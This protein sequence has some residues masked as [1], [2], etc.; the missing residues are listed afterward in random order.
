MIRFVFIFIGLFLST[1]SFAQQDLRFV[2]LQVFPD[3]KTRNIQ[4][5]ANQTWSVN[6]GDSVL[7][8]L[9][10]PQ[11]SIDE[12][13]VNKKSAH[14]ERLTD[15]ISI[16]IPQASST[17]KLS[18]TYHG[19]P[20]EAI[21][22]PWDG[23]FIWT[24]SQNEKDWL[25]VACQEQGSQLWFPSP[26]RYDD[27]PDSAQISCTY[28]ADLFFKSN[29][30]LHSDSKD[31]KENRT[32]SWKVSCPINTYNIT[33]NIGDYTKISDSFIQA[34]GSK[35]SLEYYPLGYNRSKALEQFQQVK[36]M[37]K[38][39]EKYFGKYPFGKDGFSI[40][41]TPY[42]GMEHQSA[43]AY[44]N[45]YVNGY[46]GEDY[47]MIGLGFDF[48]LIHESGHEWWGNSVSAKNKED[49]WL[50]EAFCTYAEYVY[51][52]EIFGKDKAEKYIDAKKQLVL[53]KAPI[54]GVEESGIDMYTKGALMIHTLQQFASSE[55]EWWEILKE[56]ALEF[57]WKS[58]STKELENWFSKRLKNV[59][60]VFF[61]QYLTV[62]S[63]PILDF[64]K[65]KKEN[66]YVF[67]YQIVNALDGFVM[68]IVLMNSKNEKVVLIANGELN[69][70][71]SID[72]SLSLDLTSC[73]F[74]LK[75]ENE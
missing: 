12:V 2:H 49:F 18:I 23:G 46:N 58:I 31:S 16:S 22:P 67:S 72:E 55:K 57:R 8:L 37:L 13:L 5:I 38:C 70:Y 24:K 73:Y 63:P 62:A 42:V 20:Q 75:D 41:E 52:F 61:E 14:F 48:I 40:V 11:F 54:I 21:Q 33:L 74:E 60:P 68:P 51:V 6:K 29:G 17:I 4:V 7:K 47:S 27:E 28:P 36:P 25:G 64:H 53:N 59:S 56:F 15:G 1:L 19:K 26:V 43:I 45:G 65:V 50:Q 9:L 10:Y 3:F 71:S 44:G 30:K 34:D 69:S 66:S 35:L 32:T 39:F